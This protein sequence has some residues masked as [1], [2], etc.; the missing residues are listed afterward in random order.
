MKH[1][2]NIFRTRADF[3]DVDSFN[4]LAN[5]V[6]DKKEQKLLKIISIFHNNA[7]SNKV[8]IVTENKTFKFPVIYHIRTL[9]DGFKNLP[10]YNSET[11]FRID[12]KTELEKQ[13]KLAQQ[14][15]KNYITKIK[16][17][18]KIKLLGNFN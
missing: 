1:K 15:F 13:E 14:Y 2:N 4:K 10:I 8:Q 17:I 9:C 5:F 11:H 6:Y 3:M 7:G 16:S 18:E 12:L